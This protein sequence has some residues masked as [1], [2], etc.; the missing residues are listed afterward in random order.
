MSAVGTGNLNIEVRLPNVTPWLDCGKSFGD[1]S[2]CRND[3]D[4]SN[5]NL[6]LTFGTSSSTD[7]SGVVFIRAILKNSSAAKASRMSITGL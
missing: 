7:S 5:S 1:G 2:G 6:A 3:T 4:S